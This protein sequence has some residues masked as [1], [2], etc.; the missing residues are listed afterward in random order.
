MKVLKKIR[1]ESGD[2]I[3]H[4]NDLCEA[5][6][7]IHSGSV[8]LYAENGYPFAQYIS[9]KTFGEVEVILNIRRN[10]TA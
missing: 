10:G 5:M 8:K 1:Y 7:M 4:D 9:S 3:Y 2:K 6:F